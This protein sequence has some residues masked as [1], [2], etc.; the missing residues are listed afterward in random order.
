MG[1][2]DNVPSSYILEEKTEING[3]DSSFDCI[4]RYHHCNDDYTTYGIADG[5]LYSIKNNEVI[6]L[7]EE[8][9]WTAVCGYYNENSPRTYAYAIS[10]GN[11]YELKGNTVAQ[12]VNSNVGFWSEIH[13]CTTATNN[14]VIGICKTSASAQSGKLYKINAKTLATIDN[15][16]TW[17]SCFGRYTTSTAA[18]NNCFGYGVKNNKLYQLTKDGISIISGFWKLNGENAIVK[19]EDYNIDSITTHLPNGTTLVGEQAI[20]E[21]APVSG[22]QLS[23]YDIYA[24]YTTKG[25]NNNTRYIIRTELSDYNYTYIH[26]IECR[27]DVW[28]DHCEELFD[29]FTGLMTGFIQRNVEIN[30]ADIIDGN[31]IASSFA[32]KNT[33]LTIKPYEESNVISMNI[34][35]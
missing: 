23:D 5:K 22:T 15:A 24:I 3:W 18:S 12:V 14:F 21:I 34:N 31:G 2:T 11:L 20:K 32:E 17:T 27:S 10:N 7:D 16:T 26:P 30:G 29:T 33:Y 28:E 6:L 25:F 19:L 9:V 35:L 13:G 8:R 1:F 4:S